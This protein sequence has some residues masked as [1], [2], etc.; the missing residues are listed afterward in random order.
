[1][2]LLNES[3]FNDL[4]KK[5][6]ICLA[7]FFILCIVFLGLYVFSFY[8][9]ILWIPM[10]I[11][12]SSVIVLVLFYYGLIFDKSKLLKFYKSVHTGITQEDTY[13]FKSTDDFTEH[14]GLRLLRLICTFDSDGETFERTLYFLRDLE[15]PTLKEG[16]QIKV[17]THQNI[18]VN[19]ED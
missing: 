8:F 17:R 3:F 11:G 14:D 16:Q 15:Y 10:I 18:I 19:I 13:L 9:N 2:N 5:K 6:S 4:S 12:I 1:M 7:I